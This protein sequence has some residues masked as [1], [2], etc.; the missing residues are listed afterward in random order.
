VGKGFSTIDEPVSMFIVELRD[1][2]VLTKNN[3]GDCALKKARRLIALRMLL[4]HSS[5]LCGEDEKMVGNGKVPKRTVES[6]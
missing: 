1:L 6:R 3:N 5:G 4:S 2:K